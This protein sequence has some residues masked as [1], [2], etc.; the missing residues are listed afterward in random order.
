V[1]EVEGCAGLETKKGRQLAINGTHRGLD[2][3]GLDTEAS[4]FARAKGRREEGGAAQGHARSG[5]PAE[6]A[7]R[8]EQVLG[9]Q[10]VPDLP[11]GRYQQ[12][13]RWQRQPGGHGARWVPLAHVCAEVPAVLERD[14]LLSTQA[15]G[16]GKSLCYQ[17]PPLVL[18][19][20]CVVISPLISLM[21]DQVRCFAKRWCC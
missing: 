3:R 4:S 8:A 7:C 20:P 16:A 2:E 17:V 9:L 19:Q 21:Q 6:R 13:A 18:Q 15:T 11:G 10:R 5:R 1:A 12:R 14:A